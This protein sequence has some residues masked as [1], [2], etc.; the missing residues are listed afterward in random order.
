MKLS[1]LATLP[2]R[3]GEDLGAT[4]WYTIS[5]DDVQRF[6]DAT[7]AHEWIHVDVERSRRESPFGTTVAHGYLTLS[8]ATAMVTD[9][10]GGDTGEVIGVNYGLDRVRFPEPVPVGS[11]VRARGTLRAAV[12]EAGGVRTVVELVY[13]RAGSTRPPCVAEVVSLALRAS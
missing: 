3:V 8:L 5:Q 13:E 11:R 1:D 4:P 12:P 2:D 6:A 10:L 7:R 9:L